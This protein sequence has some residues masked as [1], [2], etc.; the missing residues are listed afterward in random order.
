MVTTRIRMAERILLSAR[1][2]RHRTDGHEGKHAVSFHLSLNTE[3]VTAAYPTEPLL[4][5]P[6]ATVGE[7]LRLIKTQKVGSALICAGDRL[8]GIFT[9]RDALVWMASGKSAEV[10]ISEL[11]SKDLETLRAD[12]TVGEV[13]QQ[14]SQGHYRRMPILD[15]NGVTLGMASVKGII[16]YL[17]DHFPQT[18]YT[19]PPVPDRSPSEREGA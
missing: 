13:I 8:V 7:V 12:A 9:E 1:S 5:S 3:P 2:T 11:M 16:N 6:E 15:G 10:A 14:M 18:I 17:V 19:L 4:V